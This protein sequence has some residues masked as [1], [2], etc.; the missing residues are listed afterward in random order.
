MAEE[1]YL[2]VG[3]GN[4]GSKYEQTRH[5]VGFHVVDAIARSEKEYLELQKWDAQY[6]RSSLWGARVFFVKPQTF[7]NLSGKSIARF[8]DFFKI[9]TDHILVVHDDI[10]MHPGRLKLVSGG[11]PGG[12]NGIRS[13]IQC[14]G[15]KDFYRLKYGV[16]RPGQNGVHADIPVEKFVLAPFSKDEYE[17]LENRM[18]S[19]VDGVKAFV[20]SGSQKAMNILNALK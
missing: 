12:H 18:E 1:T 4:P 13:L 16:G 11:G 20:T 7:M 8:V 6:C 10:D 5:N 9:S 3:L 17:I 14:L 15:T 19:L 2:I